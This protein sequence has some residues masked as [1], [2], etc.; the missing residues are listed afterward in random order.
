D[1]AQSATLLDLLGERYQAGLS[2]LA[3]GRL[4]AESGARST[5]EPHLTQALTIFQ[6]LDAQP[7]RSETEAAALLLDGVGTGESII[8]PENAD[9]A[10]VRRIVDAAVLPELLGREVATA[11]YEAAAADGAVVFV[12]RD[13]EAGI[14]SF[15]G[16]GADA[17]R[18]LAMLAIRGAPYPRG[19]LRVESLGRDAAGPRF[20]A[21]A[22]PRPIGQPVMRRLRIITTV[23]RQGYAL[24]GARD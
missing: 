3:L 17:A 8:S 19:A 2:H 22:S 13:G 14:V 11:L 15:A 6:Q 24:C 1:F 18:E 21:V 7:D 4:V 5:A 10:L 23:A 9:D 12:Q 16:C 20:A